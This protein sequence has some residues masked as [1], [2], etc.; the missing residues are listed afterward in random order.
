MKKKSNKS[1]VIIL[2]VTP[3]E[4]DLIKR[5]AKQYPSISSYILDAAT[6]YDAKYSIALVD[7]LEQWSKQISDWK[8]FYQNLGTNIN[9]LAKYENELALVGVHNEKLL[10]ENNRIILKCKEFLLEVVK[11][12]NTL[13]SK[14][15][16]QRF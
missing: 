14:V 7:S 1:E 8:L 15:K 11:F 12:Q 5:K 9:Q 16:K 10:E 6:G 2:R 13:L 4:K 3:E